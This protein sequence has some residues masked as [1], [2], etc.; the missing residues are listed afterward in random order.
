MKEFDRLVE[1][2]KILR[3]EGG[4]PWD[5]EQTLETLKPC[6]MEETCEGLIRIF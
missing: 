1:I 6:L 5:R 2:I 4:C 3:G